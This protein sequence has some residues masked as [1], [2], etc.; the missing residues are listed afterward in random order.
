[1]ERADFVHLVRLSEQASADDSDR[2]RRNVAAFAMLGYFWV[3]ACLAGGAGMLWWAADTALHGRVRGYHVMVAF[4]AAGLVWTS[5]RALWIRLDPPE[6]LPLTAREA[7]DLFEALERI[8]RK[9]KGPAIHGVFLTGD[10]N[11]SIGQRPRWGLFGGAR[12]YLTVGIPLLMALD[13]QRL[14]AVLAHEYGHLRGDH[15]RFAAWVYRTRASWARFHAGLQGGNGFVAW[16]SQGFLDWYFPRFVAKTFAMARQDEYEADRISARLLG[17]E[18]AGAALVE[19]GLKDDWMLQEFWRDH[20]LRAADHPVPVGPYRAMRKALALPLPA[21][22]ARG[23]LRQALRRISGVDDTHPVLRDRLEALE[24]PAALPP[25]SRGSAL[26]LLGAR[27]DAA[28]AH[29][30]QQWCRDNAGAWKQHHAYL[31]RVRQRVKALAAIPA[32]AAPEWTEFGDL[33]RRLDPRAPVQECYEQALAQSPNHA[34][35]LRGLY[36]CLPQ[37]QAQQRMEVLERLHASGKENA[38]WAAQEAVAQLEA[39]PHHDTRTLQSWRGRLK[40]G[41]AAEQRAWAELSEPPYLEGTTQPRL[42]DFERAELEND[43]ARFAPVAAAWLLRKQL[44]EFPG[45]RAYLLFVDLPGMED[46][47]R[48]ELCRA[49]EQSLALPGSVLALWPGGSPSVGELRKKSGAP[50]Y[51]RAR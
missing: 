9:V 31:G 26:Q 17:P 2:Y 42:N 7:P 11:A 1:M 33:Q 15:G 14:L 13:R 18:V 38:W 28:I 21:A 30:D 22:F 4:G 49:L 12:N 34:D 51:E 50:L 47:E 29:F 5:L 46:G 3:V 44:R 37:D 43:L 32:R 48:W 36:R 16:I 8:R 20:W 19:I 35:A 25:W 23:A 6:G 41:E 24:V 45:R 40:E 39:D 10:L 27:A